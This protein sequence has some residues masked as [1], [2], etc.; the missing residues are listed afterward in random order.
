MG[1]T[2]QGAR[3]LLIAASLVIVIAGLRAA[4]PVLLPFLLALFLAIVTLPIGALIAGPPGALAGFAAGMAL[5]SIYEF[6]HCL[7]H[8]NHMPKSAYLKRIKRLHLAHHFHNETGN[9][10][11][12]SF[13]L[14]RLLGT[15]YERPKDMPRSP[16]TNNLG[17]RGP[18]AERYPWVAELSRERDGAGQG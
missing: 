14:D 7:Q 11:I 15:L 12:T 2:V 10:G 8:L 13:F 1:N 3:F 16:T 9:F 18:E 5:L 4:A 6:G 17:Y